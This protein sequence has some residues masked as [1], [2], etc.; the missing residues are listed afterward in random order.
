MKQLLQWAVLAAA[1]SYAGAHAQAPQ[2]E[3]AAPAVLSAPVH[4]DPY[5]P[6]GMRKPPRDGAAGPVLQFH[7]M[8][9]LKKRFE[10][11]D[12]NG[13]GLLSRDEAHKAGLG[14]VEKNFDHIDSAQRGSVNFEDLKAFIIQ[15]REEARSR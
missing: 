7:A 1:T 5:I 12:V 6:P 10:E 15:R 4:P 14:F 3:T 9:K 8:Q 13:D 11:A 2:P